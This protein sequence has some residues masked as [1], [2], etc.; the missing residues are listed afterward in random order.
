[1]SLKSTFKRAMRT[2]IKAAD[3][4]A[5]EIT[6]K[7]ITLGAYDPSTDQ[8]TRTE[9]TVTWT[10]FLYGLSDSEVDWF[11][12]D[13]HMQKAIM[14]H[15][16]LGFKPLEEDVVQVDGEDWEIMRVKSFPAQIGY[17]VFLRRT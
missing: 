16:I 14:E 8:Q 2:A 13:V 1:M 11:P 4:T 7:R 5:V 12:A 3:D 9:S 17:I 15:D 10:T 6:Y